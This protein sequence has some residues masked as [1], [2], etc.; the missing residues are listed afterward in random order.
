MEVGSRSGSNRS[1]NGTGALGRFN[2]ESGASSAQ[3]SH[4]L[5]IANRRENDPLLPVP[6]SWDEGRIVT[7]KR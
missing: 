6:L 3:Q 7:D 2:L 5:L 4:Q 1:T